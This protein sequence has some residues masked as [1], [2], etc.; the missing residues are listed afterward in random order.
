MEFLLSGSTWPKPPA[1]GDRGALFP[2]QWS[3][4][5]MRSGIDTMQTCNVSSD[6][7]AAVLLSTLLLAVD[8][9]L[10]PFRLNLIGNTFPSVSWRSA[11]C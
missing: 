3:F 10:D 5:C 4:R 11:S 9:L 8:A 6:A 1:A 2:A 7:L